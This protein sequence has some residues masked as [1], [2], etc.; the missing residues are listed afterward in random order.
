MYTEIG[1]KMA[2]SFGKQRT[3]AYETDLRLRIVYQRA[4]I[5]REISRNVYVDIATV[6]RILKLFNSTGDVT[7]GKE[8][9]GLHV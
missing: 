9:E 1:M 3:T 7:P 2:G 8:L 6:C 4:I 5:Q